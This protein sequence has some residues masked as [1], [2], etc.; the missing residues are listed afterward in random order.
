VREGERMEGKRR[1]GKEREGRQ[2]RE[3]RDGMC[4]PL[5]LSPGSASALHNTWHQSVNTVHVLNAVW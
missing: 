3:G 4:P 5:T 1:K 2:G